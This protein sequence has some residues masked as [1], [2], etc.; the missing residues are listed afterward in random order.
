MKRPNTKGKRTERPK[1]H[2]QTE[3]KCKY[4]WPF[5]N[6]IAV[7]LTASESYIWYSRFVKLPKTYEAGF[8]SSLGVE[9]GNAMMTTRHS[10]SA[11]QTTVTRWQEYNSNSQD[12]ENYIYFLY[13]RKHFRPKTTDNTLTEDDCSVNATVTDSFTPS[14]E[15]YRW[16]YSLGLLARDNQLPIRTYIRCGSDLE[17]TPP[18]D[19]SWIDDPSKGQDETWS[20][21]T[22]SSDRTNRTRVW[23]H[24]LKPSAR[25]PTHD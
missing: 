4:V 20:L 19:R 14:I 1:R 11:F 16:K 13:P 7:N 10:L 2:Q 12:V 22:Q 3:N 18:V 6:Y 17:S 24:L 25:R 15:S 5:R 23:S 9:I 8:F 21:H